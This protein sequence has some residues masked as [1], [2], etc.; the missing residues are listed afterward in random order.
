MRRRTSLLVR[1]AVVVATGG[2]VV[3]CGGPNIPK[4]AAI[5]ATICAPRCRRER[6]CN[7][8]AD[9]TA[10]EKRCEAGLGPRATLLKDAYVA[11]LVAC[12]NGQACVANVGAAIGACWRDTELLDPASDLARDH[13]RRLV[14]RSMECVKGTSGFEHCLGSRKHYTDAVV[15][16]LDECL[17][18]PCRK[19]LQCDLSVV[20]EDPVRDDPD[21]IKA[22]VDRPVP[23][24]RERVRVAGHVHE[25]DTKTPI[26][27]AEVCARDDADSACTHS[28]ADGAFAL[29]VPSRTELTVTVA[30]PGY[31]PRAL[32][33]TTAARD[34]PTFGLSL[35]REEQVKKRYA[36]L[37][38]TPDTGFLTAMAMAP[39]G[40]KPTVEGVTVAVADP[41]AKGP[42]Y[43]RTD[44]E[45]E[46]TRTATSAR[47]VA[48]FARLTPGTAEITFG[49]D[50]LACTPG[51]GGWPSDKP[52]AA[53]VPIVAGHETRVAMHCAPK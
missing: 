44:G 23:H 21:R 18:W 3:A 11:K 52:N 37:D 49:P 5:P 10:C 53:R 7:P 45:P 29:D 19:W 27:G 46:P 34:W 38:P 9:E 31:V 36:K 2:V 24:A 32:G 8:A 28:D 12:A 16:E 39:R 1:A 41:T 13:C 50:T 15:H 35:A 40:D 4:N 22:Y 47:A 51:F 33:V 6:E 25:V 14:E 30:A 48:L 43:L 20:G 17:H 26:S 42:L